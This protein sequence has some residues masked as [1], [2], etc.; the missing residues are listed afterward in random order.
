VPYTVDPK[1]FR[2]PKISPLGSLDLLEPGCRQHPHAAL[3]A[4]DFDT[5]FVHTFPAV[6]AQPAPR[7]ADE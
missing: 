3:A 5:A 2:H 4:A 7:L 1:D 6:P